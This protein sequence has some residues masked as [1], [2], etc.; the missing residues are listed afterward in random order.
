VNTPP[1][2]M[3]PDLERW[4]IAQLAPLGGG[5]SAFGYSAVQVGAPGWIWQHSIQVDARAGRKAAARDLAELARQIMISLPSVPW[6][7]GCVASVLCID[8]P[9]WLSDEDGGP[10]YY[11]RWEIRVHPPRGAWQAAPIS[12]GRGTS[13]P[14]STIRKG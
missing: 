5:V 11:A 8:G 3:Q 12:P 1:V 13:A 4:V 6:P 2:I 10:R 9:A 7:D 14:A